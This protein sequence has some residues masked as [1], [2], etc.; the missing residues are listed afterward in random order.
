MTPFSFAEFIE[1]AS[2]IFP[3][4]DTTQ[5]FN[6]YLMT[7]GVPFLAKL[8]Y[9]QE[10]CRAYLQDLYGAILLKDVV[11]RKQIRDVDLLDRIVRFVMAECGHN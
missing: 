4:E 9:D 5:L 10:A 6:R 8:G 11:R 2:P 3:G 1:A 7:G